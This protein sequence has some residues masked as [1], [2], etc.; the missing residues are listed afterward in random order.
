MIENLSGKAKELAEYMSD[1]SEEAYTAGWMDGLE[2]ALW[3]A[4][5]NGPRIYGHLEICEQ[6]IATLKRLSSEA[7]GWIYFDHNCEETFIALEKWI[8][9]YRD[10]LRDYEGKIT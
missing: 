10:N 2:Y 3:F 4:V 8:K 9:L 5:E 1:L 6:H 7:N